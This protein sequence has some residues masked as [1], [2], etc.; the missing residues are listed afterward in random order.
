M[1]QTK[2]MSAVEI[3]LGTVIKFVGAML[4][5]QFLVA[6]L[7]GFDITLANNF[8]LTGLMTI[9]SMVHGYLVRRYFNRYEV[10]TGGAM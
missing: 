6:P 1:S 7:F 2:A 5:W 4:V 8:A 10:P 9:N 3:S